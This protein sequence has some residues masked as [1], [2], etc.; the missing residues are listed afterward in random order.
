VRADA[1]LEGVSDSSGQLRHEV[2]GIPL[3]GSRRRA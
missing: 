2:Q 3:G 1:R